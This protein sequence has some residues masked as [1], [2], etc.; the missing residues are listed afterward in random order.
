MVESTLWIG[1]MC[2]VSLLPLELAAIPPSVC[3]EMKNYIPL[4]IPARMLSTHEINPGIYGTK[5]KILTFF[6]QSVY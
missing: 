4:F 3:N 1:P 2:V 6:S 5:V